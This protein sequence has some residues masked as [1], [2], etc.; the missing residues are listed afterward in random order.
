LVRKIKNLQHKHKYYIALHTERRASVTR[1]LPIE[2][3]LKTDLVTIIGLPKLQFLRGA[4][5]T[6]ECNTECVFDCFI[7]LGGRG[8]V[9]QIL[10]GAP[11]KNNPVGE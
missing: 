3:A 7:C 9:N 4:I 6:R 10:V 1:P 2:R 8:L 11:Y 5:E